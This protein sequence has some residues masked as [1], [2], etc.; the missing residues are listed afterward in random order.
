MKGAGV[1]AVAV[2]GDAADRRPRLRED[3]VLL[4]EGLDVG[5]GEVRV[6]LD[7]VDRGDDR[8]VVQQ[9]GE[10]VDHEVADPDRANLPVG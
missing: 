2:E 8:G 9:P 6:L 4:A 1:L 3:P 10:V 5:L 7:L